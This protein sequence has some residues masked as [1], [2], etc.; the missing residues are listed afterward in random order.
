MESCKPVELV[1]V[2]VE[3]KSSGPC[4]LPQ[5]LFPTIYGLNKSFSKKIYMGLSVGQEGDVELELRI[6]GSDFNGVRLSS[7]ENFSSTFEIISRFFASGKNDRSMLD[8]KLVGCGF[9]V[10]FVISHKEKA[11]EI[12]EDVSSMPPKMRKKYRR[13]VILKE[14]TF[15]M[16]EEDQPLLEARAAYYVKIAASYNF[17][18]EAI[19]QKGEENAREKPFQRTDVPLNGD[20][21]FGEDDFQ[22]LFELVRENK[23]I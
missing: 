20:P 15:S 23:D 8:Q 6:I 7:F 16:L 3:Q 10:R 9:N 11:I 22:R 13:N 5:L 19:V 14:T 1:S 4:S 12:E 21:D 2:F 17:V 18:M